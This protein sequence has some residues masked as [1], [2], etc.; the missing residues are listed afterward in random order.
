MFAWSVKTQRA[1]SG[2]CR[3]ARVY[4]HAT[5]AIHDNSTPPPPSL[6]PWPL[7]HVGALPTTNNNNATSTRDP[8]LLYS[9]TGTLQDRTAIIRLSHRMYM[10]GKHLESPA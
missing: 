5:S 9:S 7:P 1:P 3:D 10:P 6:S 8:A 2:H 4:G